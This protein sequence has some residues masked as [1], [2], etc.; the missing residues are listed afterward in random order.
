MTLKQEASRCLAN[1][2]IPLRE[3]EQQVLRLVCDTLKEYDCLEN[4]QQLKKYVEEVVKVAWRM[5][6][7]IPEYELDSGKFVAHI[8]TYICIS[9]L[10]IKKIH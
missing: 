7:H 9:V 1:A 5:V 4:C 2:N 10:T 3:V 6:C 8:P